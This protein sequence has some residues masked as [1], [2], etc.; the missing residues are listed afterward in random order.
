MAELRM[1]Q[2]RTCD[3]C[4]KL[5]MTE[6]YFVTCELGYEID[7]KALKPLEPCPKPLTITDSLKC[8]RKYL[9]EEPI[10]DINY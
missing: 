8:G 3:R 1:S 5:D 7:Q 4:V 10:R 2:K 6:Q 9:G